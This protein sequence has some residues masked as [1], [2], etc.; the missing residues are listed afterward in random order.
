[1][2]C[3]HWSVHLQHRLNLHI[4]RARHPSIPAILRPRAAVPCCALL[5][6]DGSDDASANTDHHTTH[7][8]TWDGGRV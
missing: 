6:C 3:A 7:T 8:R 1:M 5:G 2:A 4:K